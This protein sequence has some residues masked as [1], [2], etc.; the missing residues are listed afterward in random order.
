L[1]L[2]SFQSK[3]VLRKQD[4]QKQ[5]YDPIRKKWLV[6][7]PEEMVRQLILAYLLHERSYNPNRIAIE[8]ALRINGRVKRFDILVYDAQAK[9]F[10]LVECKAPNIPLDETV[11]QQIATYNLA[12]RVPYLMISN[13]PETLIYAVDAE[14]EGIEVLAEVPEPQ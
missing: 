9:P 14:N 3:L 10:L 4:G 6:L 11:V 5:I 8:K 12:L 2:L 13:G 1:D 7:Q